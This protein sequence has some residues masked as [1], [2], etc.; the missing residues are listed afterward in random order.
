MTSGFGG[1]T[2]LYKAAQSGTLTYREIFSNVFKRHTQDDALRSLSARPSNNR[3]M[4]K[5]WQR[6]WMFLWLFLFLVAITLLQYMNSSNASSMNDDTITYGLMAS[7]V[8]PFTIGLLVW[9]MD[10]HR[11]VTILDFLFLMF[12]GGLL[13]IVIVGPINTKIILNRIGDLNR[14]TSR[15]AL[16]KAIDEASAA[17]AW[18]AGITE[19][20]TKLVLSIAFIALN[21]RKKKFYCLDGLAIGAAIG[22]G[23]AFWENFSYSYNQYTAEGL[24]VYMSFA[25][26]R[27]FWGIF[28]SHM[29]FTAPMVGALCHAMNGKKLNA[30][31]FLNPLF[32]GCYLFGM[33][34]HALNNFGFYHGMVK[35]GGLRILLVQVFDGILAWPMLLYM[36]RRGINQA[37][38]VNDVYLAVE[39]AHTQAHAATAVVCRQ[40]TYA[41]SAFAVT[42]TPIVIGRVPQDCNLVLQG[43]AVSRKHGMLRSENGRVI[44]RDLG[45]SNGSRVNGKKLAPNADTVLNPGDTLEI[46]SAAERFEVA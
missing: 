46:G 42:E 39:Q 4:L 18:T 19:E 10:M 32:I 33:G 1:N 41:G 5:T 23:F 26:E 24:S 2:V 16:E 35:I 34:V 45:S 9:E 11:N 13:A 20:T 14:F 27:S 29:L 28:G 44:Y 30:R 3:D 40:G 21:S 25:V 8:V 6:P 36:L 38:A 15:A 17:T 31:C 22:A 7:L 43:E 12:F 37:L